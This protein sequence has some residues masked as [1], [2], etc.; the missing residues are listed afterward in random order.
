MNAKAAEGVPPAPP[1]GRAD[2]ER[3]L[4]LSLTTTLES[5]PLCR[6]YHSS[7]ARNAVGMKLFTAF[8]KSL[9]G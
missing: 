5:I 2:F 4:R 1:E 3:L 9:K 7:I 6:I 8:G